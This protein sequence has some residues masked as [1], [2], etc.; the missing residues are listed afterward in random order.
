MGL[1]N[2]IVTGNSSAINSNFGAPAAPTSLHQRDSSQVYGRVIKVN[3][4]RSIDFELIQDNLAPSAYNNKNVKV[5][6]AK[7]LYPYKVRLPLQNEVVPL[8]KGPNTS[9]VNKIGQYDNALYYMDPIGLF[10]TIN[11][12]QAI[13]NIDTTDKNSSIQNKPSVTDVKK[14]KIGF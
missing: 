7:P 12:N 4:D 5:G 13:L 6:Q 3:S 9:I 2:T 1:E 11:D 14:N 8:I 10:S